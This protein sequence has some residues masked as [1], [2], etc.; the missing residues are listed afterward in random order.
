MNPE[1]E[2]WKKMSA[3]AQAEEDGKEATRLQELGQDF[4]RTAS[5]RDG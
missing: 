2:H 4:P 1:L 3:E 5:Q